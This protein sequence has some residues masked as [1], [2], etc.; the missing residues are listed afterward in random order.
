MT[1]NSPSEIPMST[2]L[3]TSVLPKTLV[4]VLQFDGRH[5]YF[6]LSTSPRMKSFCIDTTTI[7]GGIMASIEVAMITG[8][9]ARSS[10]V[11]NICLMPITMV[12]IS[13]SVV[14]RRGHR[15]WFQP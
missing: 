12:F 8:Q 4:D 6:S 13:G 7:T 11:G 2:P 14:I 10:P 1:M 5:A 9:S 3:I 15:Y